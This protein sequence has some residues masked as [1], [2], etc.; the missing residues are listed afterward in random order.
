MSNITNQ[1]AA[2]KQDIVYLMGQKTHTSIIN[3]YTQQ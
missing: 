1:L 2:Q 3:Q